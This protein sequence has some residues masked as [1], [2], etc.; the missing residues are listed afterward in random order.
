MA[1]SRENAKVM[2]RE[3]SGKFSTFTYGFSLNFFIFEN[4]KKDSHK[5]KKKRNRRNG[6]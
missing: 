5:E 3:D 2:K 6:S 4:I 1:S